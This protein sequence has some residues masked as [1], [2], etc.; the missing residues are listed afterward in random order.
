MTQIYYAFIVFPLIFLGLLQF[1][2]QTSTA[3]IERQQLKMNCPFPINAGIG[4]LTLLQSPPNVNYTITYDTDAT[5]YHVT[6]FICGETSP[7]SVSTKVYTADTG[8][9]WFDFTNRAS[10]YMFY[11][12]QWISTIGGKVVAF[13]TLIWL[14]LTAPAQI[15]GLAWFMYLQIMLFSFI[16]IGIF[17]VVF[18]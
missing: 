9:Q 2:F 18:G 5:D 3:E 11:I 16:G 7:T 4:N 10:G 13:G 17:M 8:N 6:I 14:N 1:V 12:S 15:S